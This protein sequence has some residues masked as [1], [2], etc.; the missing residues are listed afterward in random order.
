MLIL[1]EGDFE[2]YRENQTNLAVPAVP[3][4]PNTMQ[5]GKTWLAQ[6]ALGAYSSPLSIF[7]DHYPLI[8]FDGF[9]S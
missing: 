4:C 1:I 7:I 5:P 6:N 3:D 8:I 2:F 9:V